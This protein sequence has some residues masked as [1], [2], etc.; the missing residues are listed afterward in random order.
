MLLEFFFPLGHSK[1]QRVCWL[2]GPEEVI[3]PP[4]LQLFICRMRTKHLHQA[5][6]R[7]GGESL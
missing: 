2:R 4:N 5:V 7:A 6:T 3:H 1:P